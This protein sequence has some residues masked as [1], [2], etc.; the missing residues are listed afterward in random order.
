MPQ[1]SSVSETLYIPLLGRIYVSKYHPQILH[2]RAALS[3]EHKLPAIVGQAAGQNEYTYLASAV[4]SRNMDA[5]IRRF[6][7]VYPG[8]TIVNV[9]CGLETLYPRNDNGKALWFELDLPEVLECRSSL[10]PE[11]AREHYLP[12]S[13]FDYRWID[14]VKQAA[15][16][17]ILVVASGL[18]YYFRKDQIFDFIRHLAILGDVYLVFDAVSTAGIQAT[19]RYMRKM[20]RSDAEMFFSVDC[21][22]RFAASISPNVSVLKEPAFYGSLASASGLCLATKA[23]MFFSDLF[24][25]VKMI[26]LRIYQS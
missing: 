12:Y 21:V 3:I 22:H 18:F 6:L 1:F 9:G 5:V 7:A 16:P 10:L 8:G 2:D 24:G 26:Q 25:M 13:M 11:Q 17:P 14:T 4:R 15:Q 20:N 23:K 19:R